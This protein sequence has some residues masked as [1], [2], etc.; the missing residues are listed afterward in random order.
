MLKKFDFYILREVL[1]PFLVA[2]LAYS[3]V[4]LMN[5]I[6]LFAELL[7]SKRVEL[8]IAGELLLD[9]LPAILAFTLP[10][11]VATG[12]L[13]ATSRL[14]TDWEI[15]AFKTLG[16]RLNRL[17]RPFFIFAFICW[18]VTLA[19]TL[20]LAPRFNDRWVRL[21]TKSVLSRI[22]FQ[23]TPREFNESIPESVLFIE[24]INGQ[25]FWSKVFVYQIDNG[26][27]KLIMA[28]KGKMNVFPEVK[29]ASFEL[30]WGEIHL[31][32]LQEPEKHRVVSFERHEEEIDVT[33]LFPDFSRK[34]RVREKDILE[35]YRDAR[36]IKDEIKSLGLKGPVSGSNPALE[37]TIE[38]ERKL[39]EW[40]S[41]LVEI[42]KRFSLPLVCFLFALLGLP[43]GMSTRRG[44]RTSGFTLSL[45]IILIYYVLITGGEKAS[46]EGQIPSWLGMWGPNLIFLAISLYLFI[47]EAR[48]EKLN[49]KTWR[50]VSWFKAGLNYW[51]LKRVSRHS[52]AA[53]TKLRRRRLFFPSILDRYLIRRFTFIFSL[54]ALALLF[55]FIIVTIFERLDNIYEHNK[56]FFMLLQYVGY[57]LPEFLMYILPLATLTTTLLTLGLLEKTN[58]ITAI[59]ASG[60]SLYR[61]MIP[62]ILLAFI[63]CG[64][65]FYLQEYVAPYAN[66]RAEEIWN[67]INDVPFRTISFL[68]RRWVLSQDGH[69]IYHFSFFDPISAV[70]YK[71]HLFRIN[72]E[73]WQLV[74]IYRAE[75]ARLIHQ[76]LVLLNGWQRLFQS[77]GQSAFFDFK[78][79]VLR[80]QEGADYFTREWKKPAWMNWRELRKYIQEIEKMGF[81]THRLKVDFQSKIS[82]PLVSLIM[83]LMGIPFAL[84]MG[85]RGVLV[86]VGLS[87]VLAIL[88]WSL[89]GFMKNLGYVHLLPPFLAI[90]GPTFL[91]GSLGLFLIA[92]IRT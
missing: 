24:D 38:K 25:N 54:V 28:R 37:V 73:S 1:S 78:E 76:E 6:F 64:F 89:I 29:K 56:P 79:M 65:S 36:L 49:L 62:F 41:H 43:L 7:I 90:W 42:H 86:G 66:R 55:I 63:I 46:L 17:A 48:E 67:K 84:T 13:A 10:M 20:F 8:K 68:D 5:Q 50:L 40:R 14:S 57:R 85:R 77:E 33:S 80:A 69:T 3:F 11:S 61:L 47:K 58:E 22:Q 83:V 21:L 19:F 81:E 34:K 52:S 26:H 32:P 31:I 12:V 18:L 59:K 30:S 16:L 88:Y 45:I 75:K 39:G 71:L 91:F 72:P 23:I 15:M 2:L 87:I 44:G 35:L 51:H 4:L 27:L 9:L 60:I 70:F 92:R 74:E 53:G 82:F